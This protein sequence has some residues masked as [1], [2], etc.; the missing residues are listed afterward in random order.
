MQ[1]ESSGGTINCLR[2]QSTSPA[3][4]ELLQLLL[5]DANDSTSF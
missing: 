4:P 3:T 1:C 2:N 5:L